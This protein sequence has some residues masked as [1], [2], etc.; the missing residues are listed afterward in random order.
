[1]NVKIR[2]LNGFPDYGYRVILLV[3][4]ALFI[5]PQNFSPKKFNAS[6]ILLLLESS[7]R[8]YLVCDFDRLLPHVRFKSVAFTDSEHP[9]VGTVWPER[10]DDA[11]NEYSLYIKSLLK[12]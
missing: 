7:A 4:H 1:M 3:F 8:T 9:C 2:W 5:L 11:S 10:M 6:L 12:D